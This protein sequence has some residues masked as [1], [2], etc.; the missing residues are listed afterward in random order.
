MLLPQKS[1]SCNNAQD[2]HDFASDNQAK[3]ANQFNE[4]LR[5]IGEKLA[6]SV[7]T[8]QGNHFQTYLTKRV[9]ESMYFKAAKITKTVN[10][11]LSLNVNKAVNRDKI[12]AY[13]K[14]HLSHQPL[15]DFN[16]L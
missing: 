4:F 14:L 3:Q 1:K 5:T 8:N 13:L 12:P 15:F 6:N 11:I 9:A 7:L 16:Q 2:L 10:T